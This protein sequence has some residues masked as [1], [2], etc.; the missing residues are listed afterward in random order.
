MRVFDPQSFK[1]FLGQ[2]AD[3][4][5]HNWG[6]EERYVI[7]ETS[8][9]KF[10]KLLAD[11]L[12]YHHSSFDLSDDVATLGFPLAAQAM[13]QRNSGMPAEEKT[14]MGNLGEVMGTE[15]ARTYLGFETTRTFPKQ[16]NPNMD[17]AMKGVDILGLRGTTR[18]PELLF[19]E[20]KT[21]KR[22]HK[23]AVEEGYDHLIDLHRKEAM[24]MLHSM[25]EALALKGDKEGVANVDRHTA[26]RVPRR[27]F[28]LI[29]TQSV[30]R[31]PFNVVVERF[32]LTQLPTLLAVHIQIQ[33]LKDRKSESSSH[34]E[35]TWLTRLFS[36]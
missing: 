2:P 7:S 21:G 18:R 33:H 30:P 29:V 6:T 20:A 27:Y 14:Q 34:E 3:R 26:D 25:K 32:K 22:L 12:Y 28:L 10:E 15:F 35:D 8:L 4:K 36:V 11:T 16:L 19:G 23:L 1:Q 5:Q 17:Q 24:W 9:R 31:E 13:R